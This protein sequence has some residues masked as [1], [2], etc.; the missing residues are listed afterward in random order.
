MQGQITVLDATA[1]A[2]AFRPLLKQIQKENKQEF[3]VDNNEL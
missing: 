1:S 2:V 3:F